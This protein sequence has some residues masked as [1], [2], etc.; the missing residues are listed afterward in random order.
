MWWSNTK[1]KVHNNLKEEGVRIVLLVEQAGVQGWQGVAA[2]A[3]AGEKIP[4]DPR[5]AAD[6]CARRER[7]NMLGG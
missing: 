6:P 5:W 4:V 1:V 3:Q 7:W 2:P